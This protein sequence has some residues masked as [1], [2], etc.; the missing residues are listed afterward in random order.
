LITFENVDFVSTWQS[1]NRESDVKEEAE[2]TQKLQQI[3]KLM[4][5]SYTLVYLKASIE[6]S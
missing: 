5:T 2:L 3:T 1:W 4:L 6:S